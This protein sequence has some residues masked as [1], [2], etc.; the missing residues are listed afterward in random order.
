MFIWNKNKEY[1][2]IMEFK[3]ILLKLVLPYFEIL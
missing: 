1:D 3:V 2:I